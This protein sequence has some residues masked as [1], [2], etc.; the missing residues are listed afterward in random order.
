MHPL[1]AYLLRF[2]RILFEIACV[3]PT[4]EQI[5]TF[6]FV[7]GVFF[8]SLGRHETSGL[9]AF[10][11]RL[12]FQACT[13]QGRNVGLRCPSFLCC[14]TQTPKGRTM[15]FGFGCLWGGL[16]ASKHTPNWEGGRRRVAFITR[17]KRK[18]DAQTPTN[19]RPIAHLSP[20]G[21]FPLP[22]EILLKG[23]A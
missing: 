14:S 5:C 13:H 15:R 9:D 21:I 11:I 17:T 2:T 12:L 1:F 18:K 8:S 16:S 4:D 6:L 7:S 3:S 10:G 19:R 22:S 23:P 20:H